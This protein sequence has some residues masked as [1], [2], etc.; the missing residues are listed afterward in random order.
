[1]DEKNEVP[2]SSLGSG[3]RL[4]WAAQSF[5]QRDRHARNLGRIQWFFLRSKDW[6]HSHFAGGYTVSPDS[7]TTSI[8][9]PYRNSLDNGGVSEVSII[10]IVLNLILILYLQE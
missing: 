9:T 4:G 2:Y 1:M 8:P 10:E 7:F 5:L 3:E 6:V